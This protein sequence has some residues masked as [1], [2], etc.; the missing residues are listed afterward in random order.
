MPPS[1]LMLPKPW[2][3]RAKAA[4]KGRSGQLSVCAAQRR[5]A[6]NAQGMPGSH[7]LLW[8]DAAS[9]YML[10]PPS[11][12]SRPIRAWLTGKHTLCSPLPTVDTP[13]VPLLQPRSASADTHCTALSGSQ[14]CCCRVCGGCPGSWIC[15]S[16]LEHRMYQP[17]PRAPYI[18][19]SLT[20]PTELLCSFRCITTKLLLPRDH[21]LILS[22][23]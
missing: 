9:G 22:L 20:K 1:S 23:S 21:V 17:P 15:A 5:G 6:T 13:R 4:L 12:T 3:S 19:C 2:T 11:E 8:A 18:Y 10:S 16:C 7:R 14:R